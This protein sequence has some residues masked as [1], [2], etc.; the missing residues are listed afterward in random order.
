MDQEWAVVDQRIKDMEEVIKTLRGSINDLRKAAQPLRI[1]HVNKS[2]KSEAE[3][4]QKWTVGV[5]W[6]LVLLIVVC[7]AGGIRL[8]LQVVNGGAVNGLM[9]LLSI[10]AGTLGS[11]VSAL[12]SVMDRRA[13]GWEF[14]T[15][16]K[17]PEE[18]P[19]D[20]FSRGMV[21]SFLL[22][23]VLGGALGWIV[24]VGALSGYLFPAGDPRMEGWVEKMIFWSF[25]GGLFAKTLLDKLN[26]LFKQLV[27][28]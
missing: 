28:Q 18:Q 9:M 13:H 11:S 25:L 16:L 15:G 5:S 17:Y 24:Y 7:V 3:E 12:R 21:S 2:L 14:S 10:F 8:F 20:K 1:E 22:R 6:Y 4:L 23:P 26:E 27:G 19:P